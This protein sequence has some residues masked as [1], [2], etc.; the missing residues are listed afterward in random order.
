MIPQEVLII[1]A[2]ENEMN[3]KTALVFVVLFAPFHHLD[4]SQDGYEGEV[5]DQDNGH[6]VEIVF[7][8]VPGGD[9]AFLDA[10]G[11]CLD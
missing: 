9:R 2:K 3:I 4:Q 7:Q 5:D 8:V 1:S 10:L 6:H 11:Q